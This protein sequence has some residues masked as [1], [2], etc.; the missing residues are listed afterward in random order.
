MSGRLWH[1]ILLSHSVPSFFRG[2]GGTQGEDLLRPDYLLSAGHY[3]GAFSKHQ[4]PMISF[5]PC[6]ALGSKYSLSIL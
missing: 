1:L 5:S 3:A 2:G 6:L 4:L